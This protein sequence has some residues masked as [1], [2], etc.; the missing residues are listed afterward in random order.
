MKVADDLDVLVRRICERFDT[1]EVI[2]QFDIDTETWYVDTPDGDFWWEG[3]TL[4]EALWY[5]LNEHVLDEE[6]EEIS[7]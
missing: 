1:T 7:E 3:E 2:I 4:Y 6:E 5:K